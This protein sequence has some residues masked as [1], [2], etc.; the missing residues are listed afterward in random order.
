MMCFIQR[1]C[2]LAARP[3]LSLPDRPGADMDDSVRRSLS[4]SRATDR[5]LKARP[6]ND[7][8]RKDGLSRFVEQA[9]R[10]ELF[11]RT[12][13]RVRARNAGDP[14]RAIERDVA[15]A[16]SAVRRRPLRGA[17]AMR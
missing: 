7:S 1:P 10:K 3:R 4:V 13:A 8:R 16:I 5:E 11:A 6:G 9:V 14:L 2:R 17:R 12:V 15:E